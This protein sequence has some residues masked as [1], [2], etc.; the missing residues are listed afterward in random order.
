MSASD[1]EAAG[2]DFLLKRF[3]KELEGVDNEKKESEDDNKDNDIGN[4]KS[5]MPHKKNLMDML[6]RRMNNEPKYDIDINDGM[7]DGDT[8]DEMEKPY[9][10][11]PGSSPT[12]GKIVNEVE[13]LLQKL[14]Q[15]EKSYQSE[16]PLGTR[17]DDKKTN[18][19]D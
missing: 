1:N 2:T 11:G 7:E 3:A 18:K 6:E 15:M 8:D 10:A 13:D 12:K 16:D 9:K 17:D 5:N 14:G 4:H 19:Y